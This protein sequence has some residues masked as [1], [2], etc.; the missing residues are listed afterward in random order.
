LCP[1]SG[2]SLLGNF[3]QA[4]THIGLIYAALSAPLL[5]FDGMQGKEGAFG[6]CGFWAVD[7][8]AELTSRLMGFDS[9]SVS[10]SWD[11]SATP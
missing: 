7:H 9:N 10:G 1:P 6:I 4:F 5:R 11:I 3:P 2:A 8:L